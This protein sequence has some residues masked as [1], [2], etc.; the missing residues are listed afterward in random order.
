MA[1]L[2]GCDAGATV[3]ANIKVKPGSCLVDNRIASFDDRDNDD[4]SDDVTLRQCMSG[5]VADTDS[6]FIDGDNVPFA[7][8]C[9]CKSGEACELC[10]IPTN[11]TDEEN[12]KFV[13]QDACFGNVGGASTLPAPEP[14]PEDKDKEADE[15]WLGLKWW[16]ILIIMLVI[17]IAGFILGKML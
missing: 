9:K 5:F 12:E 8:C 7:Q 6:A 13:A 1:L 3:G 2:S 14:L 15:M 16:H 17:V 11:C 4:P 10:D